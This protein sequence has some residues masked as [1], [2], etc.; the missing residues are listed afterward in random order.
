MDMLCCRRPRREVTSAPMKGVRRPKQCPLLVPG[1]GQGIGG[2]G[3]A[4][5]MRTDDLGMPAA[6]AAARMAFWSKRELEV[7]DHV[8][9]GGGI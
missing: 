7:V 3:V 6:W 9:L 8:L 2:E 4:E 5:G 1:E